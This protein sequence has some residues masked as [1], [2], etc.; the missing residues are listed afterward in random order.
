MKSLFIVALLAP[1]AWAGWVTQESTTTQDLQACYFP[2]SAIGFSVG[3]S[4]TFLKTG[5]GGITWEAKATGTAQTL[6]DVAAPAAGELYAAGASGTLLKSLDDGETFSPVALTGVGTANLLKIGFSGAARAIAASN[7]SSGDSYLYRST[8]SGANWTPELQSNLNIQG[9]YISDAGDVFVWGQRKDSVNY[10]IIRNGTE[11]WT[12][13][14]AVRD[15]ML[16]S[17]SV[18]YAV[19]ASGLVLKSL[20]GGANWSEISAGLAA[21]LNSLYFV[22]EGFGWVVGDAGTVALTADGALSWTTYA[23]TPAAD[24]RDI[25]VKTVGTSPNISVFAFLAGAGGNIYKLESPRITGATP[26]SIKSGWMGTVEVVGSGFIAGAY[27]TFEATGKSG[28]T[29]LYSSYESD[30]R[31]LTYI[32]TTPEVT[33]GAWDV[34]VTNGDATVS[35]ETGALVVAANGATVQIPRVWFGAGASRSVYLPPTTEGSVVTPRTTISRN[36]IMTIEAT[37]SNNMT[38]IVRFIL[39]LDG[40]GYDYLIP[41]SSVNLISPASIEAGY[42]FAL[43]TTAGGKDAALIIYTEDAAGNNRQQYLLVRVAVPSTGETGVII[44]PTGASNGAIG[45][46]GMKEKTWD[47][48]IKGAMPAF[49]RLPKGV[50]ISYLKAVLSDGYGRKMWEETFTFNPPATNKVDFVIERAKMAPY[51][52]SG[53]YTLL[54]FDEKNKK[55]VENRIMIKPASVR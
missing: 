46:G 55:I 10:A 27:A 26:S 18:G 19:G 11:V 48:E 2:T 45:Y 49:I 14:G 21:N 3:N 20:D 50:Q 23:L 12:G 35:T 47:P 36:D 24:I 15:V 52:T 25:S 41:E 53:L 7:G 17:A 22:T 33:T 44:P 16:A 29:V 31:L 5:N 54:V 42:Q 39:N 38:K 4:G 34:T 37:S 43:P 28:I 51:L 1:L 6:Y 9:T 32:I 8:D 40:A 13:T 30:S